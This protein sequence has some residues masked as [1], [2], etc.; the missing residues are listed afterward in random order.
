MY[1]LPLTL[2]S[3]MSGGIL[4]GRGGGEEVGRAGGLSS[5]RGGISD[6]LDAGGL[7]KP[8]RLPSEF[9]VTMLFRGGRAGG[10]RS[11]SPVKLTMPLL[12]L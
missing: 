12:L 5:G 7:A 8:L 1:H 10:A 4:G 3:S 9:D 6:I 11:A 2:T